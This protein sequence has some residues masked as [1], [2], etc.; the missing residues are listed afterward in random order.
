MCS[1]ALINPRWNI[2]LYYKAYRLHNILH[3]PMR[4]IQSSSIVIALDKVKEW[5]NKYVIDL[6]VNHIHTSYTCWYASG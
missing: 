6:I 5:W 3:I 1:G 2:T 4:I